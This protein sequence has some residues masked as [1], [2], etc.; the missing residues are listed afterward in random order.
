LGQGHPHLA[1][2]SRHIDGE[3]EHRSARGHVPQSLLKRRERPSLRGAVDGDGRAPREPPE[4][5]GVALPVEADH[6]DDAAYA[7][8][9][10][11]LERVQLVLDPRASPD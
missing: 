6:D 10:E 3:D 4:R 2:W 7:H 1:A 8:L 5:R 11:G 9:P